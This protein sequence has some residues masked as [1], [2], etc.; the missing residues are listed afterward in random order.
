MA[1]QKSTETEKSP[2]S[3]FG[4]MTKIFSD[5]RFPSFVPDSGALMAAHKRNMDALAAANRLAIEGAQAV[6]RRNMEIMQTAMGE[7]TAHLRELASA[8]SPKAKAARQAE[9]IKQ[10]YEHAVSNIR[11]LSDL[12]QKSNEEALSLLNQRFRESM[13]EIKQLLEK[14]GEKE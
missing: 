8:G 10:S 5:M 7:L 2:H 13:D 3:V 1:E 14:S 6:A 11:E 9:L 4:E 12:I